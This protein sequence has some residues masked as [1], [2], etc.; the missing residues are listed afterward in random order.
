MV[1]NN[2]SFRSGQE[3]VLGGH[4]SW[5]V[6]VES[7]E[8][9]GRYFLMYTVCEVGT[10]PL[11]SPRITHLVTPLSYY[12]PGSTSMPSMLLSSSGGF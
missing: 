2:G 10:I 9:I 5:E 8:G 4:K 12:H 6:I 3:V 7:I 1:K 11:N